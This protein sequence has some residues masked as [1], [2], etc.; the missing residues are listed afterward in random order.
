VDFSA[1]IGLPALP[2]PFTNLMGALVGGLANVPF[3][4]KIFNGF[5]QA[6]SAKEARREPG[7]GKNIFR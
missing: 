2:G 6:G 5:E 1:Q 3:L 4:M 7:V